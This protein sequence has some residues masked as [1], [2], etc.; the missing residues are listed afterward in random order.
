VSVADARVHVHVRRFLLKLSLALERPTLR[1]LDQR[2]DVRLRDVHPVRVHL[3]L[4]RRLAIRPVKQDRRGLDAD[5]IILGVER[6][7]Q[8]VDRLLG[9]VPQ[10]VRRSFWAMAA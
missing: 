10:P 9:Q 2:C 3:V 7:L 5:A 4:L 6:L 8:R 1:C